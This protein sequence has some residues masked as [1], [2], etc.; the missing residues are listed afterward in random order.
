M[1]HTSQIIQLKEIRR[2]LEELIADLQ[3]FKVLYPY[4]RESVLRRST[5][6]IQQYETSLL[7]TKTFLAMYRVE[8]FA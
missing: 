2:E 5:E 8:P 7:T 1:Q 3:I 6:L 4:E